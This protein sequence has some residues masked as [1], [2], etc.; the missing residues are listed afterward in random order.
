MKI[1]KIAASAAGD[2]DLCTDPVSMLEQQD[3]PA[4]LAGS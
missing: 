4:P 3:F 2:Q 1:G